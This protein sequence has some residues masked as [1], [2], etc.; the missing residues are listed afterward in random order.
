M[1]LGSTFH[2]SELSLNFSVNE[3][4]I[5]VPVRTSTGLRN[6]EHRE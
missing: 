1:F 3:Q 2:G 5:P 4:G 6:I